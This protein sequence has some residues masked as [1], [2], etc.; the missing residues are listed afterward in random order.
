ML[1]DVV[2]WG[3]LIAW[4]VATAWLA[5]RMIER[6]LVERQETICDVDHE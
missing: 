4:N 5:V 6:W 3:A 1:L 2:L